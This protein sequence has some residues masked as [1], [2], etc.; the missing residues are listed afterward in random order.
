MSIE[1]KIK[2]QLGDFCL[3]A[4]FESRSGV[5]GLLGASGCGKSLTLRSIA[6]I[7][8]PDEGRIVL[9]GNVLF[10]SQAK[11]NLPPQKRKV[12][13][14][15][16][17]YALFPHMTVEQNISCGLPHEKNKEKK[18]Q[19]VAE[20]IERMRLTG[21]EKHRPHQLS[22][23]QQQRTALARVLVGKPEILLLDEPFS[24][25]DSFLKEQL[26]TELRSILSSFEK[27]VFLVTHSRDEAYDLCVLLAL[28]DSGRI[29]GI[30]PTKEIFNDPGTRTGA[31][32]TGCKNIVSARAVDSRSV[33]IPEWGVVM[34]TDRDI[35]DG[36][37]A[38]G[39]R[40]HYFD[41][42][43]MDNSFPVQIL[44]TIEEPFAWIVKFR[45][46][47]QDPKS[48]PVWWRF[49]KDKKDPKGSSQTRLGISPE[50]ILL[51]YS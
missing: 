48:D 50:N 41:E 5:T 37:C 24:A 30:G 18:K 29:T 28:M 19:A 33:E 8:K 45:Y 38:V 34:H 40:A 12:G 42:N 31:I 4:E 17:N 15:F 6:G 10:D 39:I 32:L 14:L 46:E 44:E 51:L 22:G 27:D 47:N 21:L 36:L 25:L 49:S 23:G 26:M 1:V 35:K 16:Q 2:K 9:N 3:D 13:Y 43:I 20:M 7:V 11:I